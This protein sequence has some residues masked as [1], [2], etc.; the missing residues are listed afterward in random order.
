MTDHEHEWELKP[1]T[2]N[3][4]IVAKCKHCPA[5]MG[6]YV[7]EAMLNEHATLKRVRDV[8]KKLFSN[9]APRDIWKQ[10]ED[11]LADTQ[12]RLLNSE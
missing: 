6:A 11:A 9:D 4:L 1:Q 8:A 5:T 10:L 7:A 2:G 12:E 3:F